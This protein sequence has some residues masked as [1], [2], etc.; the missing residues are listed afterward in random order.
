[1][2]GSCA[3][4]SRGGDARASRRWGRPSSWPPL[5]P[6]GGQARLFCLG[7]LGPRRGFDAGALLH[8]CRCLE[9]NAAHADAHDDG[10]DGDEELETASGRARVVF[11]DEHIIIDGQFVPPV[12][13]SRKTKDAQDSQQT[14]ACNF[15]AFDALPR[16][17]EK[18]IETGEEE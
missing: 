4:L 7:H 2:V 17:P 12:A 10:R 18:E 13:R 14:A 9:R 1:M 3:V 5:S 8:E 11:L 15:D 6:R 16:E